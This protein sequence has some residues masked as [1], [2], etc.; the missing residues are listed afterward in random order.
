MATDIYAILNF[1][2]QG[3]RE[4]ALAIAIMIA[5]SFLVQVLIVWANG[6]TRGT[7][8]VLKEALVVFT[9]FKPA[10]DTYRVVSGAKAHVD[11]LADPMT[12]LIFS[13]N[14]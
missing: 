9:G 4:F 6:K 1:A 3:Q 14:R 13:K 10:V 8:H 5:I 12:E 2:L 7:K 11:D